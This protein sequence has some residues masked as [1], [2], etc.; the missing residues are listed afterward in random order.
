MIIVGSVLPP[1]LYFKEK[2]QVNSKVL[3]LIRLQLKRQAFN[4]S[5]FFVFFFFHL[6]GEKCCLIFTAGIF[7]EIKQYIDLK[8]DQGTGID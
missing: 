8:F 6:R 7:S 4:H 2:I 1:L 3:F 5:V